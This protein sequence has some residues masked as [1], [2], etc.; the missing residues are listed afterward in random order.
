MDISEFLESPTPEALQGYKKTELLTIA[1][2]LE[3]DQVKRS[4]RK[5][6]IK[7]DHC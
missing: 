5:D 4:M 3:L 2:K 6:E 1:N 7:K